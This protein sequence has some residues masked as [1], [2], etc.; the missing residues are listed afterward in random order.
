MFIVTSK[1]RYL[2]NLF[3]NV[4]ECYTEYYKTLQSEIKEDS[5]K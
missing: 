4:Q 1:T 3:L 5:N 2:R